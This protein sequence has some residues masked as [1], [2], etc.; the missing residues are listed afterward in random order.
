MVAVPQLSTNAS[1]AQRRRAH[2]G[3]GRTGR[4][5]PAAEPGVLPPVAPLP[6]PPWSGRKAV[7]TCRDIRAGIPFSLTFAPVAS[8]SSL[9]RKPLHVWCSAM[10]RSTAQSHAASTEDVGRAAP[11]KV[12]LVQDLAEVRAGDELAGGLLRCEVAQCSA[13]QAHAIRAQRPLP[14]L[15]NDA[16]RPA[17]SQPA[18]QLDLTRRLP[19]PEY[20]EKTRAMSTSLS[21]E[22]GTP[23]VASCMVAAA[24]AGAC[25]EA[26]RRMLSHG[27]RWANAWQRPCLGPA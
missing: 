24:E 14:K 27:I 13:Q 26:K 6:A 2:P 21:R 16:Q 22:G 8:L 19:A 18:L 17:E 3:Q 9:H 1:F 12:G 10:D 4:Q 15:I 25:R 5:S 20:A 11:G 7:G 23:I